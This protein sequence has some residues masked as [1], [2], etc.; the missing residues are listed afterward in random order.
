MAHFAEID[1]NN[2]VLR[3]VVI[4]DSDC[5]GGDYPESETIGAHFCNKLFGGT[6]KQTSYNSNF[7]KNYAGI[8]HIYN[9]E[10][11]MFV[12]PQ[13]YPSW[14]LNDEG[15]WEAPI[16]YPDDGDMYIWDEDTL[17]WVLVAMNVNATSKE[18]LE[19][20]DGVGPSLAQAIIDGRP[21]TSVNDLTTISGI[22]QTMVDGWNITV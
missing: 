9:S 5:A 11:D 17:S 7:R 10:K 20:L 12:A 1:E 15:D 6:W 13:P 14:I 22:S 21:W 16:S 19:T 4:D 2:I 3:V 8:G 18:E